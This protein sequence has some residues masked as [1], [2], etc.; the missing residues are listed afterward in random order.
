MGVVLTAV[1]LTTLVVGTIAVPASATTLRWSSQPSVGIT[2]TTGG[3]VLAGTDTNIVAVSPDGGTMFAASN[4][5]APFRLYRSADGGA[6]WSASIPL[7]GA[8]VAMVVSPNFATDMTVI[9]AT[10][11]AVYKSTNGGITFVQMSAALGGNLNYT[12]LAISPTYGSDGLLLA[13]IV[14]TA[15]GAYGDCMVFGRPLTFGW[16]PAAY[17]AASLAQDVTAVAF[18]PNF[19]QDLTILAIGS[20]EIGVGTRLNALVNFGDWNAAFGPIT[21]NSASEVG[22][23]LGTNDIISSSI[24]LPSDYN[25]AGPLSRMAWVSTRSLLGVGVDNVYRVTTAAQAMI[26][27]PTW[28][29]NN[30]AYS[31]TRTAGTL[32]AGAV[33]VSAFTLHA[34]VFR[35]ANATAASLWV[36]RGGANLTGLAGLAHVAVDPNF[37]TTNRVISGS[38]GIESAVNVSDTGG[39]SFYQA[40]VIDTDIAAITDY[41]P[42]GST[43]FMVTTSGL[44]TDSVWKTTNAGADWMRILAPP[45]TTA[46]GIIRPSPEFATDNTVF[47][48]D[49]GGVNI[50]KSS[51]GGGTWVASVAPA[52]IG[53]MLVQNATTYYLGAYAAAQV[54]KTTNNGWTYALATIT[55]ATGVSE[56]KMAANGDILVGTQNG[57]VYR[58]TNDGITYTQVGAGITNATKVVVAFDANYATNGII[59]AGSPGIAAAP[60]VGVFRISANTAVPTVTAWTNIDGTEPLNP[61][62]IAIEVASDGTLY[63]ADSNVAAAAAGGLFR[64]INPTAPVVVL[65]TKELVTLAD[66]LVG[67][68]LG[69][70]IIGGGWG[71]DGS[72]GTADDVIGVTALTEGSNTITAANSAAGNSLATYTDSIMSTVAPTMTGP[73]NK[74]EVD[75]FAA[76]TLAWKAVTGA[77]GYTVIVD[78]RPDPSGFRVPIA[79]SPFAVGAPITTLTLTAALNGLVPGTTYYWQVRVQTPVVGPYGGDLRGAAFE[80]STALGAAPPSPALASPLPGATS[81]PLR[82][83]I[84]WGAMGGA[85]AYELKLADNPEFD[86]AITPGGYAGLP[87]TAWSPDTDLEYGKTYYWKVRALSTTGDSPWSATGVFTIMTEPVPDEP[88]QIIVTPPDVIIEAAD[89]VT[90]TPIW[91]WVVIAIGALLVIAL[92]VL[93]VRTRRVP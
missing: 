79:G 81:V 80:F 59:Y 49:V 31:G 12:S 72:W 32:F 65:I 33:Q 82:P 62:V 66:G 70:A 23:A 74:A 83:L 18:S 44:T 93:I 69:G 73:R 8:V 29:A 30:L 87:G 14:D 3:T 63:A 50:R 19:P 16:V 1:L 41:V 71:L 11:T 36:F 91:V 77:T 40:G 85:T 52:T 5:A 27:S 61:R 35:C 76:V 45:V 10:T 26:A 48:A 34:Q 68:A 7:A 21:I 92:I 9:F 58:S 57:R 86:G 47:F 42:A 53:D 60:C 88:D 78:T 64:S 39:A 13:G 55:G 51:N 2:T 84:Q 28:Q 6:N 25:A 90:V 17:G 15:D 22:D 38:T 46:Y 67:T 4:Q 43:I 20:V 54:R 24:A 37:P 75:S 89:A 56:I